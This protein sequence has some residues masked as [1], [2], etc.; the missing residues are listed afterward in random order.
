MTFE[1]RLRQALRLW[2]IVLA[3]VIPRQALGTPRGTRRV[4]SSWAR[5]RHR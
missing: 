1:S 5:A 4:V 2:A 3:T